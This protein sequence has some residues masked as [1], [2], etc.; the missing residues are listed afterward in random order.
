V[1]FGVAAAGA[2]K[3]ERLQRQTHT[4]LASAAVR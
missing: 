3:G 2:C 1:L 4:A